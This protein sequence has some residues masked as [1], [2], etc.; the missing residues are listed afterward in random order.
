M[1][2]K[3]TATLLLVLFIDSSYVNATDYDVIV[4]PGESIESLILDD[5]KALI[6]G[7][8]V[9]GITATNQSVV[10]VLNTSNYPGYS[11][12]IYIA[13]IDG[14]IM[15]FYNGDIEKIN[16]GNGARLNM[17]GGTVYW[18]IDM[19][20]SLVQVH[21]SGGEVPY[22]S[23]VGSYCDLHFWGYGFTS[24]PISENNAFFDITGFWADGTPFST[25]AYN[26]NPDVNQIIFHEIPEP[27][28]LMLL[29][30]SGLFLRKR[31]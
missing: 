18:N 27:T 17:S 14:S 24:D 19:E 3:I 25:Q 7:G 13:G 9:L 26:Y 20:G 6:D 16:T 15:N 11:V 10:D 23:L 29:A 4:G 30:T 21:L 31:K 5:E 22:T 1:K 28:T 2:A 8:S 12:G